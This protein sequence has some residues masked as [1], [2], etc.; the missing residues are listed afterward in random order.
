MRRDN[1]N[2]QN[3]L[4][5]IRYEQ[6]SIERVLEILVADEQQQAFAELKARVRQ[7]LDAEEELFYPAVAALN[8]DADALVDTAL[9]EH[10][11]IEAAIVDLETGITT[12]KI[13]TLQSAI[14]NHFVSE[15]GSLFSQARD[16]MNDNIK[17]ELAMRIGESKLS[18]TES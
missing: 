11:A 13:V 1:P 9:T 7:L 12:P 3:V 8:E 15:R 4:E 17:H 2:Y 16:H 18:S 5:T 10:D 6:D 14:V